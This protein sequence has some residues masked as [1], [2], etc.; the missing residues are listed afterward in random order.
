MRS[1]RSDAGPS[2]ISYGKV[3]L[4]FQRQKCL[5]TRAI[6]RIKLS[7]AWDGVGIVQAFFIIPF[8]AAQLRHH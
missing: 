1:L 8:G 6:I 5:L 7:F 4:A 3:S 2:A